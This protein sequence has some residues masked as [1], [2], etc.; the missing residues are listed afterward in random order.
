MAEIDDFLDWLA[1]PVCGGLLARSDDG[2]TC[3]RGHTSDVAKQGYANLLGPH[4]TTHT[5]DDSKMLDARYRVLGAG[6]FD[7]M[8]DAIREVLR[9]L[10]EDGRPGPVL[11]L[12]T[13]TG[14]HL[15][16]A[17][18]ELPDRLGLG[19]DNSKSAARRVARCHP[20]S[21]AVVAD[22][23]SGIPMQDRS[24]PVLLDVFAPRNGPEVER[25]LTPD[26]VAIIVTA[27]PDH[28]AGIPQ[29]FGMIT[30][31]PEKD[32]RLERT[33]ASLRRLDSPGR[34]EW[35]MSLSPGEVA[36]IAAMGPAAGRVDEGGLEEA[37]GALAPWTEVEGQV[38]IHLF[39]PEAD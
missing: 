15:D 25:V 11:D 19:L 17:L 21:G 14:F 23:W 1:C 38:E 39:G 26:G 10:P 31:D 24:V 2:L 13:G 8:V 34:V 5:A 28:L 27:G 35:S 36:D 30:V 9:A 32:E 29:G 22:V 12:G 6:L 18:E 20:R 37:V 16:R 33:M 3:D 4:G 7:P